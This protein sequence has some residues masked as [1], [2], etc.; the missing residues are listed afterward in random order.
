M[1]KATDMTRYYV[2]YGNAV[3]RLHADGRAEGLGS[4]GEWHPVTTH[5]LDIATE[6]RHVTPEDAKEAAA[7]FLSQQRVK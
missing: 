6:Y 3:L 1:V 5:P 7:H 2:G 4:A